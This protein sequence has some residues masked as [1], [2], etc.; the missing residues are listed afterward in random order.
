VVNLVP[1][2]FYFRRGWT[3]SHLFVDLE[4]DMENR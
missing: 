1:M 3:Q 2:Y 4:V